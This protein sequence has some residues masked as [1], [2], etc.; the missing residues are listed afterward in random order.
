LQTVLGKLKIR[1]VEM[2]P[3][4]HKDVIRDL[5]R[6]KADVIELSQSLSGPMRRIQNAI[7]ECL[8]AT[9]NELKRGA[10][11]VDI[12]DATVENAIF[13]SFQTIIRRQLDP[14]WTKIGPNTKRLVADLG[15]L[16]QLLN[17]LLTY[18][19]VSFHKY[20][21][22][23]LMGQVNPSL[24]MPS[25]RQN[26]SPWLMMDAANVIFGEAKARVYIGDIKKGPPPATVDDGIDAAEEKA[27]LEAMGESVGQW[28]DKKLWWVP[29]GIEPTLEELPKWRLLR[30]VLDEIEQDIHWSS[31]DLTG[32]RNNTVLIMVD[33]ERTCLQIREYLSTMRPSVLGAAS[34][35]D[36]PGR[37][38]MERQLRYYF[39]WKQSAG[40]MRTNL[41]NPA[42]ATTSLKTPANPAS[43][44]AGAANGAAKNGRNANY[45]SEALRRKEIWEGGRAPLHK[46]RRQRGGAALGGASARRNASNATDVLES[47]ADDVAQFMKNAVNLADADAE[48]TSMEEEDEDNKMQGDVIS[49]H[50]TQIDFDQYFGLLKMEDL[51]VVRPYS[52]DD[53]DHHLQK[54]KPRFVIMYDPDPSFVRRLEVYR[55]AQTGVDMRIYFL[56]Y[57]GSVEEQRYLSHIRREKESFERLIREKATMALPLQA[58]GSAADVSADDRLLRSIHS[59]IAGGQTTATR[60]Q[61]RVIIDVREFRSS[62][63]YMLHMAGMQLE[64]LQLRVGD[65]ILSNQMCVERKSLSDL[66]QSFNKGRLY[67][68]CE[69]MSAFYTHPILLIE[70]DQNKSFSMQTINETKSNPRAINARTKPSEVDIQ[71]KLVLLTLAFPRLRIIWSS[72]PYATADIFAELK[73]NFEEPEA[74][75][76]VAIGHEDGGGEDGN[77][78]RTTVMAPAGTDSSY[79]QRPQDILLS[80]PGITTKNYLLISRSVR[81]LAEL[82]EMTVDE[83]S[84]LIGQEAGRQLHNFIHK[85]VREQQAAV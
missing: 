55:T 8:E 53:D 27:A 62:L 16:R 18:D 23:T 77:G 59:R 17:Y 82:C 24:T 79:N 41:R 9:L 73:Q 84:H 61:P 58:D 15:D 44:G 36:R 50:F 32:L 69:Q 12:E 80:L 34:K 3:R 54:L 35:D 19:A 13:K 85:N 75:K 21:E 64:P 76:V 40:A 42:F 39:D 29:T 22:L 74:D 38:M 81:D 25:G 10:G 26:Q 51:I 1:R 28:K 83:L 60:E 57:S 68:Q 2:W 71:S 48:F 5:G 65:Y 20:L 49:N 67:T 56:M 45:E 37:R 66:I 11:N 6:R 72:S 43:A 4:F 30:E 47:E 14:V 70:F 31:T 7:V 46:R 33:S 52:G 78:Q 63:P